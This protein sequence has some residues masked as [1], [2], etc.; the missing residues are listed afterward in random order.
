MKC[1]QATLN[2]CLT[3]SELI[4]P[5]V[6]M[7]HFQQLRFRFYDNKHFSSNK[8]RVHLYLTTFWSSGD[9]HK[10]IARWKSFSSY[11]DIVFSG[12][13]MFLLM[14]A[15]KVQKCFQGLLNIIEREYAL[16]SLFSIKKMGRYVLYVWMS[17]ETWRLSRLFCTDSI[18]GIRCST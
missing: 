6:C 1:S 7:L 2:I 18:M 4:I 9:M 5:K 11:D 13:A 12:R 10:T 14:L 16:S 8:I 15:I 17:P 3:R